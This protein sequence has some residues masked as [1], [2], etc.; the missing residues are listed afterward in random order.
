MSN[1]PPPRSNDR[2]ALVVLVLHAVCERRRG[3]LVEDRAHREPGDR[4]GVLGRL[5]L[6]V[7]EVR[8]HGDRPPRSTVLAEVVLGDA[9]HLR[10]HVRRDLLRRAR[11][12]RRCRP[13]RRRSRGDDLVRAARAQRAS[14][15]GSVALR[16]ISRLTPNT[17]RCG[18]VTIWRL[19]AAPTTTSPSAFHD[20]HRRRG[21]PAFL[22]V[23]DDRLARPR[24]R[25][26]TSSWCR[27][28]CR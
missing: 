18:F 24:A 13:R 9:L 14:T 16:P 4:A 10:E 27:D 2:E 17:V 15:S 6:D 26:R 7:V 22:V 1:V 20:D 21:A 28:R 5:A 23:D 12:C 8:R 3:R 25:P 19:A 11:R